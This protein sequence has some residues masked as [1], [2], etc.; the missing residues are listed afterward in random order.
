VVITQ[1][2][3]PDDQALG[4]TVPMLR[5]LA[6][7]VDEL[8]V[9][10][11][12]A[13]NVSLPPNVR[14]RKLRSSARLAR[15]AELAAV[16]AP[17]L[18]RKPVAVL[19]HMAPIYAVLAA[20]LARPLGVPVLLWFTHWRASSLLRVAERVST[21]VLTVDRASFPLPSRKIVPVGHG[22]DV[23]AF[24]GAGEPPDDGVLKLLALGRTSPA[25]GL[26][27]IVEAVGALDELPVSVEIRGPS[28]TREEREHRS[29][30]ERLVSKRGLSGRVD[31]SE[32]LDRREIAGLYG[33]IDALV[34]NMRAGA[35]DKVVYEAAATARPVLVASPGFDSLVEGLEPSLRFTQD[36]PRE[37]ALRIR[38]L[39]DAGIAARHRLGA[40]LRERVRRD[41][42][43]DHWADEVVAAAR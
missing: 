25:K 28:L 4:A 33:R 8:V 37:L 23:D 32:P 42:S 38:A 14:V 10:A 21:R 13:R 31:I 5:A 12:S 27:T 29:E 11:L 1:R 6:E 41:D 9:V 17:E 24:A 26:M 36:D 34:N 20:P 22:I 40:E 39:H 15:G 30:L 19:A 2:V 18:R 43:V 35:L 3:D 7:R 16:L